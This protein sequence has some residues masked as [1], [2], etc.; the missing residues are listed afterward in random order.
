MK[1]ERELE[2]QLEAVDVA[3]GMFE[4]LRPDISTELAA[5]EG[6][7]RPT[8]GQQ[9]ERAHLRETLQQ[10]DKGCGAQEG[11]DPRLDAILR[12]PRVTRFHLARP[13]IA[14]LLR[15]RLL[16]EAEA[17]KKKAA[18]VWPKLFRLKDG[19][20]HDLGD[21]DLEPGEVIEL[22]ETQAAAFADK[23]ERV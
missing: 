2:T 8:Y 6:L 22:N 5:L 19:G 1:T 13:G 11:T 18:E 15:E 16:A 17:Q 3:R 7:K 12:D 4:A 21:R 9:S 20:T 10:L 14:P 23:F